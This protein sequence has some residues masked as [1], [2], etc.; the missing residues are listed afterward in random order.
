MWDSLVRVC[1]SECLLC[2]VEFGA[3]FRGVSFCCVWVSFGRVWG[4]EFVLCVGQIVVG[5]WQC[6]FAVFGTVWNVSGD[7]VCLLFVR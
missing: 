7:S 6:V 3:S 1:G 4:S 5:L 2:V